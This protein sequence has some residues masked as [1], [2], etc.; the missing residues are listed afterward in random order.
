[1]EKTFSQLELIQE[2]LARLK[3]TSI[4]DRAIYLLTQTKYVKLSVNM[5]DEN[6]LRATC[7]CEDIT[8]SG[9]LENPLQLTELIELL[10]EDFLRVVREEEKYE[11]L[12]NRLEA[13][14]TPHL[15]TLFVNHSLLEEFPCYDDATS[16]I[17]VTLMRKNALKGEL[18]LCDLAKINPSHQFALESIIEIILTDFIR[19]YYDAK[20]ERGKI[21]KNILR[22]LLIS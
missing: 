20:G 16:E 2:E 7:I 13:R 11:T 18:I 14:E 22:R 12:Y 21:I 17:A 4:L 8:E 15:N 9:K 6:I 10:F 19:E 5:S 3:N 1:M